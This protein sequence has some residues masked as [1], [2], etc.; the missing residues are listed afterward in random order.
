MLVV[1]NPSL[2][3]IMS[4]IIPDE[5]QSLALIVTAAAAILTYIVGLAFNRLYFSP[6]SKIPG[7]K[8]AAL[9][10]WY[11]FYYDWWLQGKYVFEIER[12]HREYGKS[13]HG[14]VNELNMYCWDLSATP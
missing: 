9:T 5:A 7:P 14:R 2:Q 12:M 10:H 8:L 1:D 11:E 6:L 13:L 4:P 3:R